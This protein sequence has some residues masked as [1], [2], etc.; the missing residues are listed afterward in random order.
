MKKRVKKI[1]GTRTCGGGSHKKRRGKGSRGGRGNA[2][3]FSR[4]FIRSLKAGIRKGKHGFV[5]HHPLATGELRTLNVGEI[6]EMLDDLIAAGV[7]EMRDDGSV[8]VDADA[9]GVDKILGSGRVSTKIVVKA[10]K[11][12]KTAQEKIES[13]GGKC[14]CDV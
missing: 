2:G 9:L 5:R 12:S 11:I 4:H 8:F 6:E 3:T 7:A 1:R 10:A 14:I 13:A